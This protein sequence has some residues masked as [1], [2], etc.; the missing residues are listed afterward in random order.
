MSRVA[1]ALPR[2]SLHLSR[3][4][5]VALAIGGLLPI[6][7]AAPAAAALG[8]KLTAYYGDCGF[9][10]SSAGA[11]KTIKIVW[12]AADTS[13]KSTQSVKSKLNGAW[14]SKCDG[15]ERVEVGDTIKTTI[16]TTSRTFTV[17]KI[18][19]NV[20]RV[21]NTVAGIGPANSTMHVE[22]D[23]YGSGFSIIDHQTVAGST[24]G[25]GSYAVD[26]S[27]V[28]DILGWDDIYAYWNNARGDQ[29]IRYVTA[30][31]LRVWVG[32]SYAT[33]VGN[34]NSRVQVDLADS[35]DT[36]RASTTGTLDFWGYLGT[37]FLDAD[38][39]GVN[40]AIGDHVAAD[41]ASDAHLTVPNIHATAN[42]G[43]N[44]VN[45]HCLAGLGFSVRVYA[46]DRSRI[47]D[48]IG[49]ANGSG[50]FTANFASTPSLDIR[51][52][53]KMDL[54]CGLATGDIVARH[55]TIP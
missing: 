17:P 18:T 16:G 45:G 30:P 15:S 14:A 13:L 2:L 31:G 26:F 24:A 41:F 1:A 51:S 3:R 6:V 53:D 22:A 12:K 37:E 48:R 35:S 47:A 44:V 42:V 10:G 36:P 52:G 25:N 28:I 4:A 29:Y 46:P 21:A 40:P 38:G 27:G 34:P 49:T 11:S 55:S 50:N 7:T 32:R 43:T 19:A 39:A 33:V 5:L 23:T 54:Y 20:D 8:I 9:F